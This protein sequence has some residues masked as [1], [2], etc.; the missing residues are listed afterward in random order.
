MCCQN[1]ISKYLFSFFTWNCYESVYMYYLLLSSTAKC[2]KFA[3]RISVQ[4]AF[5]L[6]MFC[7][8]T[9]QKFFRTINNCLAG[10]LCLTNSRPNTTRFIAIPY[11]K[12]YVTMVN[13]IL[14][15]CIIAAFIK[16]VRQLNPFISF[17]FQFAEIFI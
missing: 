11:C 4:S 2:S 5:N 1:L 3:N 8:L 7:I 9:F 15:S 12:Q 13:H 6:Y 17:L 10:F 14:I 16:L